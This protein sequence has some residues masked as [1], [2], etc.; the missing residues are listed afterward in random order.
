M[1]KTNFQS[2]DEYIAACPPETHERLRQICAAVKKIAPEAKEKISYQIACFELNGR[3]L[4]H[5]AGWKKH[6]SLYPIPAG[7]EAFEEEISKYADGKGTVKLPLDEPLPMKLVERVIK[8][9]IAENKKKTAD[10]GR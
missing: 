10:R 2:I 6:I 8:A 5:F 4:I 9:H 7:S 3:N 1:A